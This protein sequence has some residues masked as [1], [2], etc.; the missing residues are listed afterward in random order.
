MPYLK[1]IGGTVIKFC[2]FYSLSLSIFLHLLHYI[3][4]NG[5]TTFLKSNSNLFSIVESKLTHKLVMPPLPKAFVLA[6]NW[7]SFTGV[8]VSQSFHLTQTRWPVHS[9]AA[10]SLLVSHTSQT[11]S[12]EALLAPLGG[13]L[14][15]VTKMFMHKITVNGNWFE[16]ARGRMEQTWSQICPESMV[17][18]GVD[19]IWKFSTLLSFLLCTL[20]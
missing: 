7:K 3:L 16:T 18:L 20:K 13:T 12:S 11:P 6:S 10:D 2:S 5:S 8:C 1:A 15:G 4:S 19:G 17:Q 9:A 14:W